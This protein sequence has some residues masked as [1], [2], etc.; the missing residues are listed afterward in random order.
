MDLGLSELDDDQLLELLNQACGELAARQP[1][2][3]EMAQKT[4]FDHAEKL[5]VAKEAMAAAVER[6][7]QEYITQLTLE[8]AAEVRKQHKSGELRLIS[9]EHETA[10]AIRAEMVERERLIEEALAALEREGTDEGI[11][12]RMVVGQGIVAIDL[13]CNHDRIRFE[14]GF[15][16]RVMVDQIMRW[17]REYQRRGEPRLD[18]TFDPGRRSKFGWWT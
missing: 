16:A 17:A 15:V 11:D 9:P 13:P 5:E 18:P 14:D 1:Y 7:R 2:V 12:L 10:L 4:I 3:R 6:V 8:V